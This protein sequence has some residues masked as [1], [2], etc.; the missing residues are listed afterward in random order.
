MSWTFRQYFH[1]SISWLK[2]HKKWQW[3]FFFFL[4]FL[5]LS[6][7]TGSEQ[8]ISQFIFIN[9]ASLTAGIVYFTSVTLFCSQRS[10][11]V[12]SYESCFLQY[13]RFPIFPGLRNMF[14][15][16]KAKQKAHYFKEAKWHSELVIN[17]KA[18]P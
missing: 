10:Q 12:K 4:R 17:G 15:F 9:K 3:D 11:A 13:L 14:K 7:P 16:I 1:C 5:W 8:G 6:P 2:N 18:L